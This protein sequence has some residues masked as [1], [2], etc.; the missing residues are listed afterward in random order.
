L[1]DQV[2][3]LVR[4]FELG[5]ERRKQHCRIAALAVAVEPEQPGRCVERGLDIGPVAAASSAAASSEELV[6]AE[7]AVEVIVA[8]P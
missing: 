2:E 8:P 5:I 6:I 1:R 4:R 7:L 3:V